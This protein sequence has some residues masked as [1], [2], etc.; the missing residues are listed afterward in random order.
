MSRK[1]I[2]CRLIPSEKNCTVAITGSED[3][4]LDLA[5]LHAIVSHGHNDPFE[6]RR[7]L[8]DLL[9]DAPEAA[10]PAVA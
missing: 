3:E 5:I 4:V 2:D 7:Q 6:L 8:R 1:S 10:R 9:Q